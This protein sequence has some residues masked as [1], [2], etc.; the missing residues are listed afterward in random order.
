MFSKKGLA[1][2]KVIA[3][4]IIIII[5]ILLIIDILTKNRKNRS[6]VTPEKYIVLSIKYVINSGVS[7][8]DCIGIFLT[9]AT[10]IAHP[11]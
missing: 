3:I 6:F 11:G 1:Y 2:F 10:F 4:I 8:A 7:Q 9:Q 5:I